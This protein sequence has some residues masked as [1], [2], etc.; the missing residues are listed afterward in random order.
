M[1]KPMITILDPETN[2]RITREM[3]A[4]EFKKYQSD[5]A[6][7]IE[8]KANMQAKADAKAA[9][10]DRLGITEDEAKLLLS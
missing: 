5:L 1:E 7:L 6:D 10:L 3:T 2:E 9:L 8:Y 4:A